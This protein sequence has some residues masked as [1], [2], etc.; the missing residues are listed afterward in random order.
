MSKLVKLLNTLES[1]NPHIPFNYAVP[2]LWNAWHYESSTMQTLKNGELLVDPYDFYTRIIKDVI[3]PQMKVG[4]DPSK[5][6]SQSLN[7]NTNGDW[8]KKSVLYSMMIRASTAWDHDRNGHLDEHNMY[9]MKETGTFVKTLVLLP[10]LKSMGVDTLYLLPISRFSL[11]DKKG[12]LGSPYGVSNFFALDPNLKDPITQDAM[13]LDEEF[14]ALVEAC[15]IMQMRV[16]IDIIPR[17]NSVENDLI[18]EHPDWFYWIEKKDM[19]Y[20]RPPM[21]NTIEEKTVSPEAKYM[22]DVYASADVKRHINMFRFDPKT[23]DPKKWEK[24]LADYQGKKGTVSELIEKHY[25][26]VI[27]PAFSD[28]I[29]DVQPP[30][31]DVTFFRMYLDHPEET[32]GYLDHQDTPPYILFDTIKSNLY[33]G[34]KPN[35]ALWETLSN[36]VPYYQNTFGID[37]ARID[38]GHAL[39]TELVTLILSKARNVDP[40]FSFIAEELNPSNA[41]K[42]KDAGYNMIIGNGFTMEPR[43]WQ[44][45]THQFMLES[46]KLPLPVFACGETHDTPRLAAR[47]GGNNLSKM[48][49]VMNM[50]MPNAVPF[51]NSGQE[52]YERQPMNT[53]IDC[54]DN[55]QFMLPTDDPYYG[56]LALFDKFAIH[57]LNHMRWD[58]KD[59]LSVVAKIRKAHEAFITDVKYY[60]PLHFENPNGNHLGFA[61]QVSNQPGKDS[62]LIVL[63][64]T[65]PYEQTYGK[66]YLHNV[67]EQ[68]KNQEREGTMLYQMHVPGV[69]PFVDFDSYG[70]PYFMLGP[71]EVKILKI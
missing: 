40:D 26:L 60:I 1:N 45:K 38:M 53:G 46:Y 48:L 7:S 63:A 30:W 10:L 32:V 2:D 43:V 52:V 6:L 61:Y 54:R 23:Q 47:D 55:E 16:M 41:Q 13:T 22:K 70:N 67:R 71:G 20:Y 57:Y 59:N 42:A 31:T 58:I 11:K 56:K 37:G 27:A 3:L 69:H 12:E 5:P 36:V 9:H 18:I 34:K 65:N 33:P 44:R 66:I 64:N 49:T 8:I 28:H 39:P 35:T 15:H 62:I 68:T 50:F 19:P 14:Q 51:I 4:F 21:V 24:V 25:G 17:T 29:N